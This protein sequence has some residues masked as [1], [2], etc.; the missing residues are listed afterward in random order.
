MVVCDSE[1]T[2][3]YYILLLLVRDIYQSQSR[4]ATAQNVQ[5]VLLLV[6]VSFLAPPNPTQR[7]QF[8]D[9]GCGE[10]RSE[11]STPRCTYETTSLRIF[12]LVVRACQSSS[13]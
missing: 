10:L 7:I 4:E 8:G 12:C 13:Q 2:I 9:L 11:I 1:S 6:R 5:R 3:D